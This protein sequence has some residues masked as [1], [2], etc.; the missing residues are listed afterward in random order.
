MG[1]LPQ[2]EARQIDDLR[3]VH[4]E[5][6]DEIMRIEDAMIAYADAH[7]VTPKRE[8]KEKIAK[9]LNFSIGLDLEEEKVSSILIQMPGIYRF[10]AA[11]AVLLII[12]LGGS[13]FYYYNQYNSANTQLLA[14]QGEKTQLANQVKYI[15]TESDKLQAELT[16]ANNPENKKIALAGLPI[17]PNAKAV[18]YWDKE[19]GTTYIN[20]ALL[21]RLPSNQ[22]YQLWAQV[23]GKMVDMGVIAKDSLFN[24]MKQIQ[25][26]TAFAISIE[27]LGGSPTPTLS[28]VCALGSV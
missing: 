21:P 16:V 17:A 5:L 24:Q 23:N 28:N 6:N 18:V 4:P 15:S 2:E 11:A 12:S 1:S 13:T 7:S 22:Q 3:K 20:A 26:A 10:A 9:R 19:K 8:L 27:P 14:L 25:N